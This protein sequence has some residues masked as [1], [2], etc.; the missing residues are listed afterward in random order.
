MSRCARFVFERRCIL[1][2]LMANE[3]PMERVL[4]NM[5]QHG[6]L[7]FRDFVEVALYHPEFG[8]YT[9]A[10]SPV[11]KGGDY[12]TSP[13]LSP[14]FSFT[15]GKLVREF[16]SRAGDGLCTIV[17]IGCGDGGLIHSLMEQAGGPI[18]RRR[19]QP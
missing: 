11:G 15:L 17:D 8:Y 5:L 3:T 14:A 6:D 16:M 12:I 9:Q 7:P 19:S 18:H 13:L 10:E 2:A 1:R 4:R